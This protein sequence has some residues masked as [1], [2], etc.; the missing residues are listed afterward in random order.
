M[1]EKI[2]WLTKKKDNNYGTSGSFS[3]IGNV[4]GLKAFLQPCPRGRASN[5]ASHQSNLP[6]YC[7]N[8]ALRGPKVAM[9]LL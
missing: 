6:I 3:K 4:S 2:T 7:F 1:A 8:Q 9:A 5:T